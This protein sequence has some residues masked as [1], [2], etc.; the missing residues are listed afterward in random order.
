M[1]PVILLS[2]EKGRK[3]S[4]PTAFLTVNLEM[5]GFIKRVGVRLKILNLEVL[6]IKN[7]SAQIL[8]TLESIFKIDTK[9]QIKTQPIHL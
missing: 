8:L 1:T 9:W 5:N 6:Q 7:W 3:G 4:H 2:V